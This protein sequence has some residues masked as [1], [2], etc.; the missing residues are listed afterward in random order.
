EQAL[1]TLD[2]VEPPQPAEAALERGG[3]R[4]TQ[5]ARSSNHIWKRKP[6]TAPAMM[7]ATAMALVRL[8]V[9][10]PDRP[11]PTVQPSAVTPPTPMQTAPTRCSAVSCVSRKPSQRKLRSIN[12][13]ASEP[14]TTP[15]TVTTPKV[16]TLVVSLKKISQSSTKA[17]G[18][19]KV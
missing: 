6:S 7:P 1:R 4:K 19:V 5:P 8:G 16:S 15:T 12:A 3:I 17:I 14:T 2:A 13:Q 9:D 11:W 18:A 10:S